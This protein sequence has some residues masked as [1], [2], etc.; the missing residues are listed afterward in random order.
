MVPVAGSAYTYAYATLGELF[1][2]IIG[3]DL[4]LEYAV[5]RGHGRPRLV[6]LLPGLH[7]HLR[8]PGPGDL[9]A[10][11]VRLRPGDRRD[12]SPPGAYFDLPAI[13]IAAVITAILVKGIRE[14]ATLQRRHGHR[15]GGRGAVRHRRRG[16]LRRPG[17][18]EAVRPVRMDAASAS[19]ARPSSARPARRAP[20]ECWPA[21]RSSSSPT[22]GS[23]RSPPTPRRRAIPAATYRMGDHRLAAD[24]HVLYIRSPPS[25]PA[26]S[27]TTSIHIDA[28]VSNAFEQIGLR[29]GAVH[30]LAGRCGRD[31]LG[32]AG[33]HAQPAERSSWPWP[34]TAYC[35][36]RFF[37]AVHAKFRTPWKSTILTGFFVAALAALLPLRILAE[38]V[39]IGTLF[40]FLDRLLIG[41]GHAPHSSGGGPS[42]PVP[43]YP[44]VPLAW[45]LLLHG[46][47]VLAAGG[48]LGA[49]R[50]L[51]APRR[52]DLLR[53]R[54]PSQHPDQDRSKLGAEINGPR[55]S[56]IERT[57]IR[58]WIRGLSLLTGLFCANTGR[59]VF[60]G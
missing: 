4:I 35:R 54:P 15:Q 51:A 1:A 53:L 48:K 44:F 33:H 6:E 24:L 36:R 3:W 38:L 60:Q 42:V 43:L 23:I 30:H 26:W 20:W 29:L 47:D 28:P 12:S 2:W 22:S 59:R 32:A 21:R 18:L 14:S 10:R 45:D 34:A 19:S 52:S 9:R 16:L 7:R 55:K 31:H 50:R 27:P 56:T 37:G 8:A 58:G 46:A 13:V 11:A 49:P 25:S 40:A 39:N 5:G 41:T 57:R 17:Q